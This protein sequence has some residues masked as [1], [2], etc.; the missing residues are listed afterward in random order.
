MTF[1]G[2][3]VGIA[4]TIALALGHR[5]RAGLISLDGEVDGEAEGEAVGEQQDPE[6][7]GSLASSYLQFHGP[8]EGPV[9]E[10]K[11]P[12]AVN[13]QDNSNDLHGQ[14]QQEQGY[15]LDYVAHPRYQFSYG[16]EDHRTGDFHAQKE[17]RDGK[18]PLFRFYFTASRQ[19]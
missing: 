8:V 17:T 4:L 16:V 3:Q 13:H 5:S 11:V 10:V 15:A 12:Y 9:Y 7:H 18:K 14:E 1:C 19:T 2:T 6:Q